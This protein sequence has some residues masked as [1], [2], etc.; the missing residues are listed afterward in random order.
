MNQLFVCAVLLCVVVVSGYQ[1]IK[2]NKWDKKIVIAPL[3]SSRNLSDSFNHYDSISNQYGST[4]SLNVLTSAETQLSAC[5]Q[6]IALIDAKINTLQN[7]LAE[8]KQQNLI[9]CQSKLKNKI[10]VYKKLYR[11]INNT[12]IPVNELTELENSTESEKINSNSV[13]IYNNYAV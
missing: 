10:E 9:S 3:A 8:K 12:D 11:N 7:Q 5:N 13:F 1:F 2:T 6:Q 4:K